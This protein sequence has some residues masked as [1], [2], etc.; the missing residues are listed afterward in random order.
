MRSIGRL[1][2]LLTL[3]VVAATPALPQDWR[4]FLP[5]AVEN[6][7]SFE[8]F[9]SAEEDE[10]IYGERANVWHDDFLKGKVT[11]FSRGYAYHPRFLQYY[12][13]VGAAV[14]E[15]RFDATFH[16]STGWRSDTGLDYK[17]LLYFLPEHP[18][19]LELFAL[20]WE[21]VFKD[22][23]AVQRDSVSTT[24]GADLR[25][26]YKP[27]FAGARYTDDTLESSLSSSNVKRLGLDGEYFKRYANGNQLSFNAAYIPKRY[28]SSSGL[29]GE[30]TEALFSNTLILGPVSLFSSLT[31]DEID[32]STGLFGGFESEQ[33][34][35]YERMTAQLPWNFRTDLLWRWQDGRTTIT[36][37]FSASPRELSTEDREAEFDLVHQLY[38]SL[39]STFV[40]RRTW[41]D[42]DAG[43]NDS[44][45]S[46]LGFNYSKKIPRGRILAGLSLGRSELESV[47]TT[48]VTDERHPATGVP[49]TFTLGQANVEVGSLAVYLQSPVAPY[50]AVRLIENQH[51]VVAPLG[52]TLE[53]TV[54]ALPPPFVVPGTFDI[55]VSYRLLGGA[56]RLRSDFFGHSASVE[57]FD[58]L[59]TPYYSYFQSESELVEGIYPGAS[60]DATSL[61]AGLRFVRGPWRARAEWQDVEWQVSPYEG[62]RGEVQYIG[63][64]S[65]TATLYATAAYW[66]RDYPRGK[67][68]AEG[69]PLQEEN[70]TLSATFDQRFFDRT[71]TLSLGASYSRTT[72]VVDTEGTSFNAA[73][74]WQIGKLD[75]SA[76]ASTYGS[77]SE[78]PGL[79]DSERNHYYYYLK[80]RRELF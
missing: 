79:Q 27:W 45:T 67:G 47:G 14:K 64:V 49:G 77:A 20:R 41:R 68:S 34:V 76:G 52:E 80:L 25:Y 58:N 17:A 21:P 10:N 28:T 29:D 4:L 37:P 18:Y 22:H 78:S 50:E 6:G 33:L 5:R 16:E 40:H 60:P 39:Q 38:E 44:V 71:L 42:S 26:A 65:R 9:A 69:D 72:S 53:V 75:L 55:F 73:L 1:L 46:S 19:H 31:R 48:D 32:Q 54:F 3:A 63:P 11:L 62:W 30:S 43:Q 74:N 35:W 2:A 24:Y 36:D 66:R 56:F 59:L 57:L 12:L 61:I 70:E 7:G 8:L 13:E 15:E 51:Y 23:A